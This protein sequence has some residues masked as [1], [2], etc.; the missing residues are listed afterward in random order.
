MPEKVINVEIPVSFQIPPELIVTSPVNVFAAVLAS[1]KVPLTDVAPATV[2]VQVL[3][4]P[5]ANVV[6]AFIVSEPT[7]IFFMPFVVI[8]VP[9]L[10][11]MTPPEPANVAGHS[12]PAVNAAPLLYR[13]VAAAPNVGA[14]EAVTAAVPSIV[15]TL[16][17]VIPVVVFAPVPD[18]VKLLYVV[19]VTV[20]IAPAYFTVFPEAVAVS[21]VIVGTGT[22]LMFSRPPVLLVRAVIA[23]DVERLMVPVLVI[24][25][26]VPDAFRFSV[27]VFVKLASAVEDAALP[28]K[29]TVPA[30][31]R[32]VTEMVPPVMFT[33]P[34]ELFD[35]VPVPVKEVEE[36]IVP[37]LVSVTPVTVR[38]VAHVSVP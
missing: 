16:L 31:E 21:V 17:T 34:E 29:V 11:I 7:L 6:P 28:L 1:V 33:M 9:V 8:I 23:P 13:S 30:L 19:A 15:R 3:V 14:A 37:L 22:A 4:T 27:P 32:V 36:F 10:S 18:S 24:P 35:K 12:A 20:C 2:S 5:V 38:S 26:I 25:V